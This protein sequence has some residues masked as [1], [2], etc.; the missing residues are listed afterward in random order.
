MAQQAQNRQQQ[1]PP[2]AQQA[3]PTKP[4][5][6]DFAKRIATKVVFTNERE[7]DAHKAMEQIGDT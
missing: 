3:A 2:G 4:L 1:T 5:P 6:A 7:R